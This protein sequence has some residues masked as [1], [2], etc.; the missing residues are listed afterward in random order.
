MTTYYEYQVDENTTILIAGPERYGGGGLVPVARGGEEDK[1]VIQSQKGLRASL[2]NAKAS[3]QLLLDE[4]NGLEVSEAEIKFGLTTTGEAGIFAVGKV[5]ME[6]NYEI[7]LK[8]KNAKTT[9]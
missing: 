8:W 6:I 1:T 3:A 5:G 2:Q 9:S 4:I 7:T